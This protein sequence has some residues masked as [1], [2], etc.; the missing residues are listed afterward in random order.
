MISE[1]IIEEYL[2][3]ENNSSQIVAKLK[4]TLLLISIAGLLMFSF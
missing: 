1:Q 3:Q 4:V 2:E